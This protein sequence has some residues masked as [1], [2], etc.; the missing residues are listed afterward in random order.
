[1]VAA[2]RV[3]DMVDMVDTVDTVDTVA[4]EVMAV[5]LEATVEA[6]VA[7]EVVIMDVVND[8]YNILDLDY[9]RTSR[10]FNF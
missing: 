9:V 8:L 3:A 5:D 6:G 1:L 7:K 4:T 10:D 2:E